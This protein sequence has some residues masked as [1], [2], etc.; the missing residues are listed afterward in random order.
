MGKIFIFSLNKYLLLLVVIE[1]N[2]SSVRS[3]AIARGKRYPPIKTCLFSCLNGTKNECCAEPRE[4]CAC[5]NCTLTSAISS[6]TSL[7]IRA[8]GPTKPSDCELFEAYICPLNAKNDCCDPRPLCGCCQCNRPNWCFC[9]YYPNGQP[10]CNGPH[11]LS[12][13][14]C[15]VFNQTCANTAWTDNGPGYIN[16]ELAYNKLKLIFK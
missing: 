13:C 9:P 1:I 7:T 12:E 2:K 8:V 15:C 5:C 11:L 6:S 3:Q 16:P 4:P 14:K 10:C